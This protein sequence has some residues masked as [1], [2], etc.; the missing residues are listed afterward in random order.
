MG[1]AASSQDSSAGLLVEFHQ[2]ASVLHV[3][4]ESASRPTSCIVFP[5]DSARTAPPEPPTL[6]E[7][8][9]ATR[10]HVVVAVRS[11]ELHPVRDPVWVEKSYHGITGVS[12]VPG[13][14][15]P[16]LISLIT[17]GERR[18]FSRVPQTRN[19][20]DLP[21]DTRHVTDGVTW[22]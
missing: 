18:V 14:R 22:P 12:A 5:V 4:D 6:V 15:Q 7:A 9:V 2:H 13:H 10:M 3:G 11:T 20:L 17:D 1:I 19:T 16:V 8:A 21:T